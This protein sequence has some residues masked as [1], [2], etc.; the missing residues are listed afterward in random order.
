MRG[1]NVD[2]LT[3]AD[4]ERLKGLYEKAKDCDSTYAEIKAWTGAIDNAFPALL[5]RIEADREDAERYQWLRDNAILED[6][7]DL[8]GTGPSSWDWVIRIPTGESGGVK[9]KKLI[10]FDE[11]IGAARKGRT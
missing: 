6:L 2:K 8:R 10:P 4:L 9:P 5:A 1:D 11:A 3:D 7:Y